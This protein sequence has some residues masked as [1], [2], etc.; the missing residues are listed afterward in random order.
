MSIADKLN[1]GNKT[2]ESTPE[3][4]KV[5]FQLANLKSKLSNAERELVRLREQLT[6]KS[7]NQRTMVIDDT[8]V[9]LQSQ[10]KQQG[11]VYSN[12]HHVKV[13][14]DFKSLIPLLRPLV[15][16]TNSLIRG[17]DVLNR[18]AVMKKDESNK[19]TNIPLKDAEGKAVFLPSPTDR[20]QQTYQSML[21]DPVIKD[22]LMKVNDRYNEINP[23]KERVEQPIPRD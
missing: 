19:I 10:V 4:D 23:Q 3:S 13:S 8:G 14:E 1:K 12:L 6:T 15:Q 2:A 18:R 9:N 20:M 7:A 17:N 16:L 11:V 21:A 22:L 5:G